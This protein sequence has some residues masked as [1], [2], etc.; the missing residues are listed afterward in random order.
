LHGLV[1]H[2]LAYAAVIF[3][4]IAAS[5]AF[6]F[7]DFSGRGPAFTAL[8]GTYSAKCTG[9]V[10]A[11]A[12]HSLDRQH[13]PLTNITVLETGTACTSPVDYLMINTHTTVTCPGRFIPGEAYTVVFGTK[14]IRVR[15]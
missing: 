10:M 9:G 7:L 8:D 5:A 6:L 2:T 12:V 1:T 3:A 4:L 14:A 15:C 13:I 11:V